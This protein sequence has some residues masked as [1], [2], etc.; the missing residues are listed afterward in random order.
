MNKIHQ[1]ELLEWAEAAVKE[2]SKLEADR[3]IRILADGGKALIKEIKKE[4]EE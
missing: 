1:Q 3:G 2:L 4:K